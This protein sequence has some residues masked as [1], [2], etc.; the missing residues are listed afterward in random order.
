[1]QQSS[2]REINGDT[3]NNNPE[4]AGISVYASGTFGII[5]HAYFGS[6]SFDLDI[7]F[8]I[9]L[10]V[11][12]GYYSGSTGG[13]VYYSIEVEAESGPA[14]LDVYLAYNSAVVDF[15]LYIYDGFDYL[16]ASSQDADNDDQISL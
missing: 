15:D 5:I 1:M 13:I 7:T 2:G 8:D 14:F 12:E 10:S 16:I 6:G 4:T 3:L 11:S 9:S